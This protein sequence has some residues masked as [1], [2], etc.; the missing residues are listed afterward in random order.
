MLQIQFSNFIAIL[1]FVSSWGL[2]SWLAYRSRWSKN[3]LSHA[4]D[5]Y[6][7]R[8]MRAMLKREVRIADTNIASGLQ[9]GTAFFASAS[10]LAI[11]GTVTLLSAMDEVTALARTLDL[12]FLDDP[13]QNEAKTFGLM[14]ILAYAFFKFGWA[15][16]LFNYTTIVMGSIP[17]DCHEDN[18]EAV[19]ASLR[20]ARLATLAGRHFSNGQQALFFAVGYLGWYAGPFVFIGTTLMVTL[21]LLRRQFFSKARKAVLPGPNTQD[22]VNSGA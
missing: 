16:R 13:I 1:V 6:R 17:D 11:G 14:I 20:A 7:Y 5:A 9:Q 22:R 10:L 15:Y 3:T 21:V 12:P 19:E 8:W 2:Y 4:M 18:E